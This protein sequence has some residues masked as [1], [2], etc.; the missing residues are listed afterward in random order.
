MPQIPESQC[1]RFSFP[2]I[3]FPSGK[4]VSYCEV[5]SKDSAQVPG[6]WRIYPAQD[7]SDTS[8]VPPDSAVYYSDSL[9]PGIPTGEVNIGSFDGAVLS[10]P[11]INIFQPP[12]SMNQNPLLMPVVKMRIGSSLFA[13]GLESPIRTGFFILAPCPGQ[14]F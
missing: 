10:R 11:Q 12:S 13:F 1:S 6:F 3:S 7:Q 5:I 8:R 9:Y 4:R 2:H 14:A